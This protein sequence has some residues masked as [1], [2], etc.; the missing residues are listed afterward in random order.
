MGNNL[1]CKTTRNSEP[2]KQSKNLI[3]SAFYCRVLLEFILYT[4]H[5]CCAYIYCEYIYVFYL[6]QLYSESYF[7]KSTLAIKITNTIFQHVL[8]KLTSTNKQ[9]I[10]DLS[11]GRHRQNSDTI[12]ISILYQGMAGHFLSCLRYPKASRGP[13][14]L[15]KLY[16]GFWIGGL[17]CYV[18]PTFIYQ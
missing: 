18:T 15:Q 3:N 13:T 4:V 5:I 6:L 9:I 2:Q 14:V 12:F 1:T 7:F 16:L 10:S 17:A 11:L 8:Y